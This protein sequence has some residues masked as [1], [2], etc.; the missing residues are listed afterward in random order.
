MHLFLIGGQL[1]YNVVSFCHITTWISHTHTYIPSILNRLL[2]L[3][4]FSICENV[5]SIVYQAVTLTGQWATLLSTK[6]VEIMVM[7]VII[8]NVPLV[9]TL[10]G[11]ASD[12]NPPANAGDITDM[13]SIPGL[14]RSPVG[15]HDNA[16]QYSCLENLMDRGAWQASVHRSQSQTWLKQRCTVLL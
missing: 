15:G 1:L 7:V 12:K 9:L 5:C 6:K 8:A 2:T 14:Q 3:S 13:G 4:Y 11:G 16:L 10:C